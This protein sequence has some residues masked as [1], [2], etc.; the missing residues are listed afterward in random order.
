MQIYTFSEFIRSWRKNIE[1]IY[2]RYQKIDPD[3]KKMLED[4]IDE[5]IKASK[6]EMKNAVLGIDLFKEK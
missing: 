3:M 6:N 1:V 4:T 2:D 5:L